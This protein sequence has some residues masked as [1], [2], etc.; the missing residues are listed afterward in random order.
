V[1]HARA[2]PASA[3]LSVSRFANFDQLTSVHV[4][5]TD[6]FFLASGYSSHIGLYDI[7]TG[8]RLQIFEVRPWPV[9]GKGRLAR[10]TAPEF[11]SACIS[12]L[13]CPSHGALLACSRPYNQ[14]AL[15]RR[16]SGSPPLPPC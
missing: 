9:L 2:G 4:N 8:K 7:G 12:R 15:H 13:L 1:H 10:G 3:C 11:L 14:L 16:L 5:C 6:Q